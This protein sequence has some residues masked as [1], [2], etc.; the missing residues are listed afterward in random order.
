MVS[1]DFIP[2]LR[3][4]WSAHQILPAPHPTKPKL[5][6]SDYARE[7]PKYQKLKNPDAHLCLRPPELKGLPLE[8]LHP[9]FIIFKKCLSET[10][11]PP[12]MSIDPVFIN[13]VRAANSLCNVMGCDYATEHLR[14]MAFRDGLDDIFP[15]DRWKGEYMCADTLETSTRAIL[16]AVYIDISTAKPR[17][18]LF[19]QET[20]D[21]GS[22]SQPWV[23][24]VH[25]Y[26]W[27]ILRSYE[28]EP[29]HQ[30]NGAATLLM[31]VQ[32]KGNQ[33]VWSPYSNCFHFDM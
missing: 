31:L 14:G 17:I 18:R 23:Q 21:N 28:K 20:P 16:D 32:G 13:A 25:D 22:T 9:A 6:P 2:E 12:E 19:L 33:S 8:I 7:W 26:H 10:Y 3:G 30:S 1:T 5:T 15:S 11:P 29:S 27:L 24:V 4:L